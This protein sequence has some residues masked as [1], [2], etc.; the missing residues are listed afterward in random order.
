MVYSVQILGNI[1]R[2]IYGDFDLNELKIEHQSPFSKT[3]ASSSSFF[4]CFLSVTIASITAKGLLIGVMSCEV[5]M[6]IS[7]SFDKKFIGVLN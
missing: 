7:P 4:S 6:C 2:V 5:S 3:A 1:S